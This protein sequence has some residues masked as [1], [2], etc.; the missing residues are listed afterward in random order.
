MKLNPLTCCDSYK[1]GHMAQYPKGTEKVYANW[2]PRSLTY[3]NSLLFDKRKNIVWFGLQGVLKEMRDMWQKEFFSKTKKELEEIIQ[4]FEATI[5]PFVGPS[6]FD[7][8]KFRELHGLGFLPLEFRSLPEGTLVPEGVPCFTVTNTHPSAYWL[9]NYIETYLSAELW[10]ASTSATIAHSY[11]KI[12]DEFAE[13]T[14]SPHLFVNWQGHDFSLRGMGGM[15]DGA[16]SGAGHLLSFLGTDNIPAI[17]YV[18]E[19]YSAEGSFVGGSV[20]ATEHSVM[21][22]GGKESEIETFRRLIT[23]VYPAGIVSIVSDTWD[24]WKVITEY[25]PALKTEIMAR[26]P[27]AFGNAKTV[28]RPDSGDPVEIICGTH[29]T[30]GGSTAE[31]KG[32]IECLWDIFGG[33]ITSTGHKLLD[34]HVGLIYG[35]SITPSRCYQ[36][37]HRLEKKGFASGNVV[38][39]IGS[40]TYQFNTRDTLGF[41]LKTT[42]SVVNGEEIDIYKSPKTDTGCKKSAVG[43]LVV[44]INEDGE[45]ALKQNQKDVTQGSLRLVFDNGFFWY[46][47]TF[48]EIRNRLGAIKW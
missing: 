7:T 17:D 2:T 36:I 13:K 38:L 19:Y 27:D 18:N 9:V 23:E 22:V 10:K 14:G 5:A 4:K 12:L 44:Y 30:T 42:F 48:S 39:G 43:R 28:F 35:D 20:P 11:R 24:F 40:F 33:T 46:E 29:W 34:S 47:E 6:G 21:C 15:I 41:A 3:L 26:K 37:L 1:L 31:E 32:A 16:Q 25:A 8:N 45:L